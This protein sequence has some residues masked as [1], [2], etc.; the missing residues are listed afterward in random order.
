MCTH[1]EGLW[2]TKTLAKWLLAGGWGSS[3]SVPQGKRISTPS[4]SRAAAPPRRRRPP[5]QIPG[6]AAGAACRKAGPTLR[7]P[8]GRR[9]SGACPTADA[10][11]DATLDAA[12][13]VT[14][15]ATAATAAALP[16]SSPLPDSSSDAY[17]SPLDTAAASV[18]AIG[19]EKG[20]EADGV[21]RMRGDHGLDERAPP[22]EAVDLL[23]QRPAAL[24]LAPGAARDRGA[25]G[26]Q[27]IDDEEPSAAPEPQD[28][29]CWAIGGSE[30]RVRMSQFHSGAG[31]RRNNNLTM[32]ARVRALRARGREPSRS[33]PGPSSAG[34]SAADRGPHRHRPARWAL[35]VEDEQRGRRVVVVDDELGFLSAKVA[36]ALLSLSGSSGTTTAHALPHGPVRGRERDEAQR[37][38]GGKARSASLTKPSRHLSSRTV[39]LR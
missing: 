6:T 11:A 15:A 5:P 24:L 35:Q 27:R 20:L 37:G 26:V 31:Y 1:L 32:V 23:P 13:A 18:R 10:D 36:L 3:N 33:K 25:V 22:R 14:A 12:T 17:C 21:K 30:S 2:S 9:V 34:S 38:E 29:H 4:A 19:G 28:G 16:P 8:L 39:G 7:L